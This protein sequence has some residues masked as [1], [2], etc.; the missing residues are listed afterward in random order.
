METIKLSYKTSLKLKITPQLKEAF[1]ILQLP[2]IGLRT[3]LKQKVLRNPLLQ[4]F[5]EEDLKSIIE[6]NI[7]PSQS[8]KSNLIDINEGV[9]LSEITQ[10]NSHTLQDYLLHQLNM[11]FLKDNELVIAEEIIAHIDENGYL[12]EPLEKL[13]SD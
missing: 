13:S 10:R 6:R 3:Y 2:L 4:S 11:T 9:D 1:Y 7:T 8:D 5:G 12:R